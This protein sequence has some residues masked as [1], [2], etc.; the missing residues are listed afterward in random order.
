MWIA[1]PNKCYPYQKTPSSI[2]ICHEKGRPDYIVATE[3]KRGRETREKNNVAWRNK[4][5]KLLAEH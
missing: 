5:Q 1:I 2:M 4:S 3:A